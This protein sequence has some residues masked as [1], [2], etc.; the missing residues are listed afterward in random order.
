MAFDRVPWMVGPG[1]LTSMEVAR[2]L[3]YT[4]TNGAEGIA[5]VGDLKVVAQTVPNGTVRVMPGGGLLLNRYPQSAGQTYVLRCA[6][7]TDVPIDP[8]GSSGPRTDLVIARILDPQY[9]GAAPANPNDFDYALPSVIKGVSSTAT[10]KSL[11]LGYPAIDLARVSLPANTAAVTS[12]MITDLRRVAQPRRERAMVTIF[13][14]SPQNMPAAGYSTW[15]IPLEQR[16]SV[17]VPTWATRVDIVAH[18]SGLKYTKGASA[19][20]TVAGVRTGFG[21][22]APGEN[23]ILIADAEDTGGRYA[24][25]WIGTHA[26]DASMRGTNQIINLQ[27]VRSAGVGTW[28]A[29]YQTSVVIDWEFSEGA[30]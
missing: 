17:Y 14:S 7:A 3:A 25:T 9:E 11:G 28:T 8:T 1:V 29:D 16:P 19:T 18:V 26:I 22:S 13:P 30:Q 12:A 4:A 6:E 15:P 27:A 5:G 10:V 2:A 20:D 23:G 24:A 21:S